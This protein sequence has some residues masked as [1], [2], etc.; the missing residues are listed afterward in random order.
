MS[1]DR[2]WEQLN[3][4]VGEMIYTFPGVAGCSVK[5]MVDGNS[6]LLS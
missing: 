1:K 2:M 6:C 5:S 3:E 4:R